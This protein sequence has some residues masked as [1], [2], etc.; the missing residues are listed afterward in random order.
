MVYV[1]KFGGTSLA[2]AERIHRVYEIIK[3]NPNR[4]YIVVSNI[5][6]IFLLF[7][8]SFIFISILTSLGIGSLIMLCKSFSSAGISITRL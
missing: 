5:A 3:D 1:C 4:K 8:S 2:N 7:Y 6:Y